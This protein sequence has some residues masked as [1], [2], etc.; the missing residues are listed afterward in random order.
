MMIVKGPISAPSKVGRM[1]SEPAT[2]NL[3]DISQDIVACLRR[4]T[5]HKRRDDL[6]DILIE[7]RVTWVLRDIP[8]NANETFRGARCFDKMA[9]R[10]LVPPA[11]LAAQYR[12]CQPGQT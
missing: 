10:S 4:N 12:E 5:P 7:I 11:I 2:T 6:K 1:F 3:T 9:S 8:E